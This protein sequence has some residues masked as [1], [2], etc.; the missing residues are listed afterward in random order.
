MARGNVCEAR[1]ARVSVLPELHAGWPVHLARGAP[2]SGGDGSRYGAGGG[3]AGFFTS[4]TYKGHKIFV[5]DD[6]VYLLTEAGGSAYGD[7]DCA[8]DLPED[9]PKLMWHDELRPYGEL[10]P[11][12]SH[13]R[14]R[15]SGMIPGRN[16]DGEIIGLIDFNPTRLPSNKLES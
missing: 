9:R 7:C 12:T 1:R 6:R 11:G 14:L 5:E 2:P 15:K 8:A 16:C 10:R 3:G 13:I 4:V